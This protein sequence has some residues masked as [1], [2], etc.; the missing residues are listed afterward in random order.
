[1]LRGLWCRSTGH[2]D[3]LCS[4][5]HKYQPTKMI[6]QAN[7]QMISL[8]YLHYPFIDIMFSPVGAF[9]GPGQQTDAAPGN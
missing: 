1:M 3:L 5:A 2:R 6:T 7:S 8:V 9:V 4:A